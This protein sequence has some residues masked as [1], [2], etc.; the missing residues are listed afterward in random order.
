MTIHYFNLEFA[1]D[2]AMSPRESEI[3]MMDMAY[4]GDLI[5]SLEEMGEDGVPDKNW[6]NDNERDTQW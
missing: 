5:L 4:E 3:L 6:L 2:R 1:L